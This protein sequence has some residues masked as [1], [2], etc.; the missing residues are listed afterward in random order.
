MRVLSIIN[1]NVDLYGVE[2]TGDF[3]IN[4]LDRLESLATAEYF[5][6]EPK[7]NV[8]SYNSE[9]SDIKDSCA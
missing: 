7:I 2:I 9:I 8:L 5:K 1:A 3:M 6:K 4:S